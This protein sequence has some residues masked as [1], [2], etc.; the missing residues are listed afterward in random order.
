[1]KYFM[2]LK[3][4]TV[5]QY[6]LIWKNV[7]VTLRENIKL[8]HEMYHVTP[9]VYKKLHKSVGKNVEKFWANLPYVE[10]SVIRRGIYL[11]H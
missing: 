3:E 10:M 1:M 8:Q 2:G 9:F 6:V 11:P 7:Q 5:D 4:K